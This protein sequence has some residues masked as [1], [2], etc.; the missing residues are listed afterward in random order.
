MVVRAL[1]QATAFLKRN[2]KRDVKTER[3][4][5]HRLDSRHRDGSEG[6]SAAAP[7]AGDR[8]SIRPTDAAPVVVNRAREAR[9]AAGYSVAEAAKALGRSEET[10]RA[11]ER[12]GGAVTFDTAR[13]LAALYG[14]SGNLFIIAT[15]AAR[16]P[17]KR[18]VGRPAKSARL[19]GRT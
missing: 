1:S 19:A 14:C 17:R 16:R 10:V 18:S 6:I 11:A 5:A 7:V 3:H 9:I 8:G 15:G 13:R 12:P 2:G 4:D